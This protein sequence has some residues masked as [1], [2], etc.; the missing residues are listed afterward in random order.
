MSGICVGYGIMGV[1]GWRYDSASR[2]NDSAIW[3]DAE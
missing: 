1:A 2:S 3:L